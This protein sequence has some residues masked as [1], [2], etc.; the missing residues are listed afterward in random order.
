M[1]ADVTNRFRE[2]AEIAKLVE[3]AEVASKILGS[4]KRRATLCPT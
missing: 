3:D 1:A 2:I 4:D